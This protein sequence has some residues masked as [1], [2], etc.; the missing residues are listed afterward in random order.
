[1]HLQHGGSR[2][3]RL[4]WLKTRCSN[5]TRTPAE[6]EGRHTPFCFPSFRFSFGWIP[7]GTRLQWLARLIPMRLSSLARRVL[8]FYPPST[9]F[10]FFTCLMDDVYGLTTDILRPNRDDF[11]DATV[12]PATNLTLGDDTT[13]RKRE[14][15]T[16]RVFRWWGLFATKRRGT[17]HPGLGP[18]DCGERMLFD[19]G[20]VRN[21]HLA[22][23]THS[24]D[25]T[26]GADTGCRQ[27]QGAASG[28]GLECLA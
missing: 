6:T 3:R 22:S 14:A 7:V 25:M 27:E 24:W 16:K 26:V 2:Y 19:T 23:G 15:V 9:L 1:M 20:P 4:V 5:A 13:R 21:I 18:D 10:F 17:T 12:L 8:S 28:L 11:R